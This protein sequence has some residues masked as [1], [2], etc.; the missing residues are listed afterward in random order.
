MSDTIN[1]GDKDGIELSLVKSGTA[2]KTEA[3]FKRIN[4]D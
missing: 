3:F 4:F 1:R 2:T